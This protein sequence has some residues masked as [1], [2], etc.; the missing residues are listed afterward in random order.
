MLPLKRSEAPD[1]LRRLEPLPDD[2][3]HKVACLLPSETR[4]RLWQELT[5]GKA[6]EEARA[7]VLEGGLK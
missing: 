3:N 6:P 5:A 1:R 7:Q 2:P 4:K